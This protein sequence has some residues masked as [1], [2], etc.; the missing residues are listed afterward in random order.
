M[1]FW[2]TKNTFQ[3]NRVSGA[4]GI[5]Q[6]KQSIYRLYLKFMWVQMRS[7]WHVMDSTFFSHLLM[8]PLHVYSSSVLIVFEAE[9]NISI[10]NFCRKLMSTRPWKYER[11]SLLRVWL[12]LLVF[13][14]EVG[15]ACCMDGGDTCAKM[16]N[17]HKNFLSIVKWGI[18]T[19]V[20]AWETHCLLY[21]SP[22]P[23]D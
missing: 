7:L 20:W 15:F 10:S 2:G 9:Q 16:F 22:S 8:S 18:K 1:I 5:P 3:T 6:H 17:F 11:C 14:S 23:R 19:V 12:L 4:N 13:H 21:T